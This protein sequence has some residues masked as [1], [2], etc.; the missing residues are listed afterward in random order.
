MSP[1]HGA[2]DHRRG[3]GCQTGLL[4]VVVLSFNKREQTL[5][6]LESVRRLQYQPR[7]VIVV[8]NGSSDGSAD[9]VATG[10]PEVHLVR[11]AVNSGAAGGRNLGAGYAG[12]HF[13]H[14]YLLFVDD[15]AIVAERLADA[16]VASLQDDPQAGMA[17]PKAYR[18]DTADVI[19][20]AGGMRVRLGHATITDI[21]AGAKDE[22]QYDR[23]DTVESCVG[24]TVLVRREVFDRC[25]GF[26]EAYNPYGWE[27]VD[28]SLRVRAQGQ[29]IRYVPGAVCWHA[30]GTPGRGASVPEYEQG[31][32]ANYLRLMRRHATPGEWLSFLLVLPVRGAQLLGKQLRA[33]NWAIVRAQAAGL[34]AGMRWNGKGPSG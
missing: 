26:D 31:K 28:L 1:R 27:E 11:S 18:M 22:G 4:A 29:T 14:E 34:L 21:G 12:A 24:F 2:K 9:A 16:L 25:G 6:C 17:T 3:E 13:P 30:G 20:S 7:E 23:S 5:R 15:D 33:G 8:D 10:F 19:A 32:I